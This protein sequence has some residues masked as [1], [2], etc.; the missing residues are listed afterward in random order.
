MPDPHTPFTTD[1]V[2]SSPTSAPPAEMEKPALTTPFATDYGKSSSE[3]PAEGKP[4]G[5]GKPHRIVIRGKI[6]I[7]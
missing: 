5:T 6:S 7:D 2:E 4:Y 3:T 1:Y